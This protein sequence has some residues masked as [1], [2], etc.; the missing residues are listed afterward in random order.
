MELSPLLAAQRPQHRMVEQFDPASEAVFTLRDDL[1][2]LCNLRS[3]LGSH[4]LSRQA[5]G[6]GH[7]RRFSSRWQ[8][9]ESDDN[10]GPQAVFHRRSRSQRLARLYYSLESL[11][12]S[13]VREVE[14]FQHF[15]G[16]P[17]V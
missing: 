16:A 4:L 9:T 1:V 17:L 12:R 6:N 10:Q 14:M 7:W 8:V 13:G 11:D 2:H 15:R 3:H 5:S